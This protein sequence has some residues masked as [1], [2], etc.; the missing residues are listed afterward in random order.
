VFMPCTLVQLGGVITQEE[1][2]SLYA[3]IHYSF[4]AQ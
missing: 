2:N 1:S 4:I 3:Y